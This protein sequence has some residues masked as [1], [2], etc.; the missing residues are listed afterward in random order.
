MGICDG[1]HQFIQ[2]YIYTYNNKTEQDQIDAS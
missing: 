2:I 1:I